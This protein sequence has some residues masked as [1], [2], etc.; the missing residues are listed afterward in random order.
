[1]GRWQGW[2]EGR[3]VHVAIRKEE[4]AAAVHTTFSE[5]AFAAA[6][7][8][9]G[10]NA[11][12]MGHLVLE[13]TLITAAAGVEKRAFSISAAIQELALVLDT[14]RKQQCAAA[15]PVPIAVLPL[16]A[17]PALRNVLPFASH[18]ALKP[19]ASVLA[20]AVVVVHTFSAEITRVEVSNVNCSTTSAEAA[21]RLQ[22]WRHLIRLKTS[23]CRA[24]AALIL[25]QTRERQ[26]LVAANRLGSN[27]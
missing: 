20:A 9:V 8:G 2:G 17:V 12:A 15:L 24:P 4:L 27:N 5:L 3:S 22:L 7:V 26:T 25:R 16:V 19:A 23:A 11:R 13:L 6:T 21:V 10:Q 1:M 18:L 14:N